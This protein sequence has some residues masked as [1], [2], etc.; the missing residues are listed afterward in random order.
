[1]LR[2]DKHGSGAIDRQE[3]TGL[4]A[5]I[6]SKRN[7][8]EELRKVF[9]CYDNDD[10]G[11]ISKKNLMEC[12]DVLDMRSSMNEENVQQ[13]IDLG[14]PKNRG[15]VELKDFMQLMRDIGLIK[16]EGDKS[17]YD[18]TDYEKELKKAEAKSIK[19]G[20]KHPAN[21]LSP[22]RKPKN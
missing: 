19:N 16:K 2:V 10:D 20:G 12:A 13:M 17:C 8:E 6:L 4:M 22:T 1:M 3:F 18:E 5:E 21:N 14:D 11:Q 15:Y 7:Q 9:R